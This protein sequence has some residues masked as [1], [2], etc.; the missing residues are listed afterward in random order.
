MS[1]V[2]GNYMIGMKESRSH[3]GGFNI[4]ISQKIPERSKQQLQSLKPFTFVSQMTTETIL[5]LRHCGFGILILMKAS[6]ALVWGS[7]DV[8]NILYAQVEGNE[9]KT[10]QRIGDM[11]SC[12]GI[13]CLLGPIIANALFVDGKRP[14]T[15]QIACIGAFAI[16]SLGW[17][18]VANAPTFKMVCLFTII[19][20]MGSSIIW[21]NA[22]LLLQVSLSILLLS[23]KSFLLTFCDAVL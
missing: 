6:G 15:M 5:Y 1:N 20:T 18:L 19:R 23:E 10:S 9:V 4:E 12:I 11:Y 14:I 3:R 8:L 22:T 2:K 13:G 21:F 7:A 17:F 16:T